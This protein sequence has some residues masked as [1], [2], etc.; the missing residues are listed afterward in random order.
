MPLDVVV[1]RRP[2][3]ML[4]IHA[5]LWTS[6]ALRIL[7]GDL[8]MKAGDPK[9][10]SA[11]YLVVVNFHQDKEFKPLALSKLVKALDVQGDKPEAEKYRQQLKTEF[12]DWTEH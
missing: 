4:S 2:D 10:A 12:P 9:K 11:E 7:M 8:E 6:A 1:V 3:G 5:G